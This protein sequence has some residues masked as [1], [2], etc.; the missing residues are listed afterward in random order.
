MID[1]PCKNCGSNLWS[2]HKWDSGALNIKCSVCG[3]EIFITQISRVAALI[4]LL[5]TAGDNK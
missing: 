1:I 5:E 3:Y 4:D 2:L